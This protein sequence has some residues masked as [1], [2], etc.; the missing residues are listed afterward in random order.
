MTF[1]DLLALDTDAPILV[2]THDER[3]HVTQLAVRV[4]GEHPSRHLKALTDALAADAQ[5]EWDHAFY[6][7]WLSPD[8]QTGWI[9]TRPNNAGQI[10]LSG[11]QLILTDGFER[12]LLRK[13]RPGGATCLDIGLV[14]TEVEQFAR[15]LRQEATQERVCRKCGCTPSWG[16][17]GGCDW[18]A[19]DL[20]TECE[21][22]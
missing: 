6:Q 12:E 22:R 9:T 13:P 16:C 1:D 20:C 11:H 18:V 4:K 15:F 10:L 5:V 19:D 7:L 17:D 14:A 2:K 8:G 3:G 21:R